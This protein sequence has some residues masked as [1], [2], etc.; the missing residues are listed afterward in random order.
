MP[1]STISALTQVT[2]KGTLLL[3]AVDMTAP[4]GLKNVAMT[5]D[6]LT[7][8]L[9]GAIPLG[10]TEEPGLLSVDG[11]DLS[12]SPTGLL[13]IVNVS[14]ATVLA[15]GADNALTQAALAALDVNVASFTGGLQAA[16]AYATSLTRPAR[17]SIPGGSYAMA[18]ACVAMLAGS[19]L[20]VEAM[21]RAELNFAAGVDGVSL[22]NGANIAPGT[23]TKNLTLTTAN[24]TVGNT[25]HSVSNPNF[26]SGAFTSNSLIEGV[27]TNGLWATHF[28]ARGVPQ[29]TYRDC[30]ASILGSDTTSVGFDIAGAGTAG[31][32]TQYTL[33]NAVVA[34]G[35]A[36]AA[37]F[38]ANIQGV[39]LDNFTSF[40]QQ[41]GIEYTNPTGSDLFQ[42]TGGSSIGAV[43]ALMLN[44][45]ASAIINNGQIGGYF[46]GVGSATLPYWG[47]DFCNAFTI[48]NIIVA[49][50]QLSPIAIT[51]SSNI[52]VGT[53]QFSGSSLTLSGSNGIAFNGTFLSFPSIIGAASATNYTGVVFLDKT[54]FTNSSGATDNANF[55][56][57]RFL[58]NPDMTG[59]TAPQLFCNWFEGVFYLVGAPDGVLPA[60][61]VPSFQSPG[62]L[63]IDGNLTVRNGGFLTGSAGTGFVFGNA[64][65]TLGVMEGDATSG[66]VNYPKMIGATTGNGVTFGADGED[67]NIDVVFLP[68]GA[69]IMRT[70]SPLVASPA[71]SDTQMM[72][73]GQFRSTGATSALQTVPVG[74]SPFTWLAPAAG[75]A[76]VNG[77]SPT[78]IVFARGGVQVDILGSSNAATI[79]VR[80]NDGIVI[81]Y[82]GTAPTLTF[83]PAV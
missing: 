66:V 15:T 5:A 79:G 58:I 72:T 2:Y 16:L 19:S 37:K 61:Y 44:G 29:L 40:G 26:T 56:G 65:G 38:G 48:S 42:I 4:V 6:E 76:V 62:P 33:A 27:R 25:A 21:G 51:N 70:A 71:T 1:D 69:G 13:K 47:L 59:L 24:T 81:E 30:T 49:P 55:C 28:K 63:T 32:S 53:G 75:E 52:T 36:V 14:Q 46:Y 8:N 34:G 73:L 77:G 82:T 17:V 60:N 67:V 9:L 41:I 64:A 50:A 7:T 57:C 11:V 20:S 18:A 22:T 74:A 83:I 43:Q 12:A 23:T 3:P 68:K 31:I 54:T 39:I 80:T 45:S 10:S 78:A 35:G